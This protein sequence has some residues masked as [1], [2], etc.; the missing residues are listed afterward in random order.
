[1]PRRANLDRGVDVQLVQCGLNITRVV[2]ESICAYSQ[3]EI[4]DKM[5]ARALAE[6]GVDLE[7]A[8]GSWQAELQA[9]RIEG[10]AD[11]LEPSLEG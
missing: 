3:G 2:A 8:L 6:V 4:G 11:A 5:L 10:D 7:F 9:R 1:M